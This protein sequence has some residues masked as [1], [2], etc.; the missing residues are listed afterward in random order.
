[1]TRA[2][3]RPITVCA[4]LL[5]IW[6]SCFSVEADRPQERVL[7]SGFEKDKLLTWTKAHRDAGDTVFIYMPGDRGRVTYTVKKGAATEGEW[8]LFVSLGV[9]K[10]PALDRT[11]GYATEARS[12]MDWKPRY[13][14][15]PSLKPG[16]QPTFS[17]L[18][19]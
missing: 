7:F 15:L 14:V 18:A 10:A 11:R 3:R 19:S 4:S 13:A 1:M 12:F 2:M 6:H 17:P 8:A 9:D 16:R 5:W